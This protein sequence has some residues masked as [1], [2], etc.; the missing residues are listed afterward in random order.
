M[1]VIGQFRDVSNPD[2]FVWLRGFSDMEARAVQLGEFYERTIRKAHRDAANATM[3]D[4]DNVLLFASDFADF[5]IPPGAGPARSAWIEQSAR[6]SFGGD[7]LSPW[8]NEGR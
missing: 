6:R 3:I 8:Q 7:D 5:R 4:S 1:T 2:R